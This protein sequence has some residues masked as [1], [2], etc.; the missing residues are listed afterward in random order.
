[1]KRRLQTIDELVGNMATCIE[2]QAEGIGVSLQLP[3]QDLSEST[4]ILRPGTVAIVGG[5]TKA[6]KSFFLLQMVL[7]LHNQNIQWAYLPLEDTRKEFA[8]RVLACLDNDYRHIGDSPDTAQY[9]AERLALNDEMLKGVMLNVVE[10]PRVGNKDRR[11]KTVIPPIEWQGIL[12]WVERA[13]ECKKV[14]VVDPLSQIDFNQQNQNAEETQFIRKLLGIALD[15]QCCI[16]LSAHTVKR[17]GR[18]ADLPL[19][20]GDLQGSAM[21]SR[22]SHT[23]ILLEAHD[24]KASDVIFCDEP[25]IHNRTVYIASAR[26][27]YGTRSRIA[28]SQSKQGPSFDEHGIIRPKVRLK[29]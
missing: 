3:W 13:A 9:R 14:I 17:R 8:F 19:T 18:D 15:T 11:G 27:G 26:N 12:E 28:F 2:N 21:L 25:V 16:I 23:L 4:N 24:E 29:C 6:G 22:L 10:N 20:E 5:P 1:M 7:H